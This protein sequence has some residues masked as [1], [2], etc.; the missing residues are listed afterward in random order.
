MRR[1]WLAAVALALIALWFFLSRGGEETSV[2]IERQAGLD[3]VAAC[4][5]AAAEAGAAEL[6]T[7]A[8][9]LPARLEEGKGEVVA[10]VAELEA[11]RDGLSCRWDGIEPARLTRRR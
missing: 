8:D 11:R 3:L 10:L 6:F 7:A 9:V 4:N 2:R 5:S 1:L